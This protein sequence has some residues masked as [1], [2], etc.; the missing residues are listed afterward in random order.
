M[1]QRKTVIIILLL[2]ITALSLYFLIDRFGISGKETLRVH[3]TAQVEE[4]REKKTSAP[5]ARAGE[6]K[7]RPDEAAKQPGPR[8]TVQKE[9][10][11]TI[12]YYFHYSRCDA[13]CRSI[14]RLT[15]QSLY[16]YFG[17]Q[18]ASGKLVWR[19]VNIDESWNKHFADDF[20]LKQ[21]SIVMVV[22]AAN[23]QIR[24]KA[25]GEAG[26]LVNDRAQFMKYIRAEVSAIMP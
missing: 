16:T 22:P 10:L 23:R 26:S 6:K 20:N 9:Y 7:K 1:K 21:Q 13:V 4:T 19:S 2:C 11:R 14:E 15:A 5:E 24:W 3:E 18:L 17:N 8:P 25:L 12:V